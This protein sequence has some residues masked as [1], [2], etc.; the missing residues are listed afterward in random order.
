MARKHAMSEV[1]VTLSGRC[2]PPGSRMVDAGYIDATLLIKAASS[3]ITRATIPASR[4]PS[5]ASG[6][7]PRGRMRVRR[8]EEEKQDLVP[9]LRQL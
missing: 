5:G 3:D 9:F 7:R 2:L 1:R 8:S 4:R 6:V